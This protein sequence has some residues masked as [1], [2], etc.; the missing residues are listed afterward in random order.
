LCFAAAAAD[1]DADP[2][3]AQIAPGIWNWSYSGG[4]FEVS[5]CDNGEFVCTAYPRH[6]HWKQDLFSG[7]APVQIDWAE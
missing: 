5:F 2:N 7:T 4:T 1:A 6:A 3:M